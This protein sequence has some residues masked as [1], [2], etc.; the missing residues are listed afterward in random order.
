MGSMIFS[1]YVCMVPPLVNVPEA[2]FAPAYDTDP[3]T[4]LAQ[5]LLQQDLAL[6]GS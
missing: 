2:L 4:M 6:A 3:G 5:Q 1:G